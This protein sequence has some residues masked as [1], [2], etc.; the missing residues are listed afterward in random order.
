MKKYDPKLIRKL[1]EKTGSTPKSIR[2]QISRRALKHNVSEQA[3][4]A[5][6][7]RSEKI[8]ASSYI[9]QLSP[10]IKAQIYSRPT[11]NNSGNAPQHTNLNIVRIGKDDNSLYN[12]LWFQIIVLGIAVS[13]SSQV[14]GTL[15]T[16]FLG[17][18]RP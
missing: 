7:A 3:E 14:L 10:D 11:S 2:E 12:Q 13:V 15:I 8:S 1:S 18:T 9:R 6:W 5:N 4:L 17:L 16:N